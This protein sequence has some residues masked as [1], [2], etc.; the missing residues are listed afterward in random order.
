MLIPVLRRYLP[1]FAIVS[2][3][4]WCSLLSD[5]PLNWSFWLDYPFS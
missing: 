4:C 2:R 1:A 3:S 5:W